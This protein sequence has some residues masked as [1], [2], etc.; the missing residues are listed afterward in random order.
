MKAKANFQSIG[1]LAPI[2]L[3]VASVMAIAFYHMPK[4]K[5]I[6]KTKKEIETF[7]LKLK[8]DIPEAAILSAKLQIDTIAAALQKRQVRV[9]PMERLLG[10]G[11]TIQSFIS[12]YDLTLVTLKPQYD[13]LAGLEQDTTDIS[14]LPITIAVKGRFSSITRLLDNL[15]G[16]PFAMNVNGISMIREDRETPTIDV[17]F[18]GIVF[19]SKNK[20]GA[21]QI[22]QSTDSSATGH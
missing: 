12:G 15:T 10:I 17:E 5:Q 18:N 16:L 19:F 7:S 21:G 1:F 11:S 3:L 22:P 2:L 13:Q 8:K 14:E 4:N 20:M 6:Q 9:Y